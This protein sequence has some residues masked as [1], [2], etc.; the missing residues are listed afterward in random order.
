MMRPRRSRE[1]G[2]ERKFL[3]IVDDTPECVRAIL[4]AAKRAKHTAG[5]LTLLF[6]IEPD[7]FQH[8]LGVEDIMRAEAMEA[9]EASLGRA[10]L[11]AREAAGVEP[12]LVIR[13][14]NRAEQIR[15]LI[16]EDEDIAVLVLAASEQSEGPG[17]LVT[18]FVGRSGTFPIPITIVPE[19]LSDEALDAIA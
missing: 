15:K 4:Y 16:E 12:E 9:A 1:T 11:K 3:V 8:W 5:A 7:D 18:S 19:T 17:P 13:E 2:H 6:V 10:A 14:G